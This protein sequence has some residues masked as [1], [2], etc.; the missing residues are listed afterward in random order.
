MKTLVHAILRS[1]TTK[2]LSLRSPE[3]YTERSF[4]YT[5]DD[6]A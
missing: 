3:T 6:T 1:E 5:Q 4:T 2:D